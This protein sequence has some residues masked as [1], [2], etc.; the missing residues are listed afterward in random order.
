MDF[1]YRIA[2]IDPAL[3]QQTLGGRPLPFVAD[4]V[5]GLTPS[6]RVRLFAALDMQ[7]PLDEV[8]RVEAVLAIADLLTAASGTV[9][10]PAVR[11][12]ALPLRALWV[13][14]D[15]IAA[16]PAAWPSAAALERL[17]GLDRWTLAR[18]FRTAFGTSPSRFRTMRQLDQAR[19]LIAREAPLAEAAASA[20][21]ADQSHMSRQFK[22][23]YG[24]TP[25]QWAAS[26]AQPSPA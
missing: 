11:P 1:A 25:G 2:Y 4:P 23:A 10:R 17:S 13:V 6:Q 8:G 21:F 18:G 12:G 20:G 14:R 15:S 26:L 7:S 9:A 24:L 16:D 5:I 19:R 3:I 22:R